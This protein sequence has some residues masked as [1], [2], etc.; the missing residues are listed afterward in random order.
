MR[1]ISFVVSKSKVVAGAKYTTSA[2]LEAMVAMGMEA[3]AVEGQDRLAALVE[4]K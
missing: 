2:D 3:G 4:R 1:F